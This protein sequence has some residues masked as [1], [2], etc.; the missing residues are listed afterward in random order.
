MLDSI[1]FISIIIILYVIYSIFVGR[2]TAASSYSWHK[3]D[4]RDNP[5]QFWIICLC[6]LVTSCFIYYKMANGYSWD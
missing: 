5:I 1:K 2:I 3:I 4:R 6:Y